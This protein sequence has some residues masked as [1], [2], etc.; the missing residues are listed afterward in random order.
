MNFGLHRW[1]NL[2]HRPQCQRHVS[3][4]SFYFLL[5]WRSYQ[6]FPAFTESNR[7]SPIAGSHHFRRLA[8]YSSKETRKLKAQRDRWLCEDLMWLFPWRLS[9]SW[10]KT[11]FDQKAVR[12]HR[13]SQ[14]KQ[15]QK[16][17]SITKPKPKQT[18]WITP[19]SHW[20]PMLLLCPQGFFSFPNFL[21][22]SIFY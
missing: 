12:K 9:D 3:T 5:K 1:C 8:S 20:I 19:H 11:G 14:T 18:S 16:P 22:F 2:L 10:P 17:K 7:R 15:N 13:N 21:F 4:S 6:V